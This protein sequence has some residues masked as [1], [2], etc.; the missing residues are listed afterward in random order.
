MNVIN[1]ILKNSHK[2]ISN[3][4]IQIL[5]DLINTNMVLDEHVAKNIRKY[6][7]IVGHTNE[8]PQTLTDNLLK[9]ESVQSVEFPD[10]RTISG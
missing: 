7:I 3:D 8:H 5:L 1:V 6:G 9:F 2:N 4:D 10:V